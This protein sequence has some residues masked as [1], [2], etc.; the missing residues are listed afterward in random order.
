[1]TINCEAYTLSP[2]D[3]ELPLLAVDAAAELDAWLRRRPRGFESCE[4]LEKVLRSELKSPE[5]NS[6]PSLSG[7]AMVGQALG[8]SV[9]SKEPLSV[10]IER[11][12]SLLRD[13][14]SKAAPSPD[15]PDAP[16]AQAA[17]RLRDFF[18]KLSETAA[19]SRDSFHAQSPWHPYRRLTGE[20]G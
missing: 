4:C 7:L 9:A 16:E 20:T 15:R 19:A 5:S 12:V 18:V 3:T 13:I 8:D 2:V 6:L 11:A 17:A 14:P 1:M 10:L